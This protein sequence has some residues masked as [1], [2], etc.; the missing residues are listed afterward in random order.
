MAKKKYKFKLWEIECSMTD[1]FF[2][3]PLIDALEK[4]A[5]FERKTGH[6]SLSQAYLD[7]VKSIRDQIKEQ[8][9]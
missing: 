5:H 2:A 1:P 7:A 3:E 6:L 4:A 8:L 9:K